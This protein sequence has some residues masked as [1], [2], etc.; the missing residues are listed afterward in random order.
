VFLPI[1]QHF[2]SPKNR[3]SYIIIEAVVLLPFLCGALAFASTYSPFPEWLE[4]A[5]VVLAMVVL[6]APYFRM[7]RLLGK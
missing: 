6:A 1:S 2:S 3:A 4:R 7:V 5:L